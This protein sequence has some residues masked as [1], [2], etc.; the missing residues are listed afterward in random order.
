MLN[1]VVFLCGAALMSIE[2]VAARVL[3]PAL[4]NSIFVWGSVISTVMIALS[5]G[6]WLGGQIADRFG[7]ARTLAPVIAGAGVLTVLAPIVAAAVL[8][9]SADLGPRLGSLAAATFIFF[10]PALLLAMVTPLGVRLAATKGL[11]H[12]GRSAGALSS[13]STAGSI[14]GTLGTSFWLIPLLSLE[15]LI[16][17]IGFV[18]LATALAALYLPV[19]HHAE[20]TAGAS[21]GDRALAGHVARYATAVAIAL[22]VAGGAIGAWV[23]LEV[24]PPP[25]RNEFGETVLF[26]R[27]TQYHR[28]TVTESDGVRH[29]RFDRSHQ[30]AISLADGVTSLIRYPDYLQLPMAVQPDAQ[31]VL[32][33]GLGGGAVSTR[34]WRDYPGMRVD[35]VEIDPVVVDV[36]RRYFSL[37]QDPRLRVFAQ[38]G[39]RYVQTAE[40]TYDIIVLDAYYAD[41]LPFH[42]T[43]QE[44]LREVKA[45][46][47]PG[48]VV[49]YNVISGLEGDRSKLFRSMHRTAGTVWDHVWVFP[50]NAGRRA[51]ATD[52]QNIAVMV[53]DAD[54]TEQALLARIR[55]AVGG[56]VKVPGFAGM[57]DDLYRGPVATDG[58]PVL[59][60]AYAPTDS[61]IS[62]Q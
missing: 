36:A 28:I 13:I 35:S 10:A 33:I 11:A 34:Y 44:F 47:R 19:F 60:D 53:T 2:I 43:T 29:L 17:S 6:Y 40:D 48:G 22:V 21:E 49:V 7:A 8:P 62:V 46:L 12:I 4:G 15:P 42:L 16:V 20:A 41:S 5:L 9:F 51:S 18:L 24:A 37:P 25:Q 26:R 30:S 55:D 54:I 50:V 58:A 45:R 39:R 38:D 59:T 14:L 31:R 23:L 52:I 56:R 32:V 57:A 61:L 27:D 1:A 3:A